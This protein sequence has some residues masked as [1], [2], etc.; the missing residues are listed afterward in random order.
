MRDV[1]LPEDF[2][3]QVSRDVASVRVGDADCK[4]A[5]RHE[6]MPPTRI[7]TVKAECTKLLD[8]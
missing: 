1:R 2:R 4:V 5:A 3:E 7:R 8:K 6:E